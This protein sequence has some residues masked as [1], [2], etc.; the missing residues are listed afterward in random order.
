MKPKC[1]DKWDLKLAVSHNWK[2]CFLLTNKIKDIK[3]KWFQLR[4]LHRC[5]G[6]NVILKE[7][8][9]T[10]DNKCSF[11]GIIKDSID[12]MFWKCTQVQQ[13]WNRLTELI[14]EKCITAQNIRL[15]ESFVLLGYDITIKTDAIF[16]F[17]IL[18]AKYYLYTCKLERSL[19]QVTVFLRKL[20]NRYKIEEYISY[21]N[22]DHMN[23]SVKWFMY[24]TML[25]D[26]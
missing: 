20:K 6:T 7:I 15:T 9:V 18:F 21:L 13:F 26:V 24:K 8:G 14:A 22:F 16:Y 4:I 23:F 5:L 1:C 12:H 2:L 25:P 11:C 3:L 10:D 17:I 19:P